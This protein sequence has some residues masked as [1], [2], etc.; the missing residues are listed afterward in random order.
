MAL[1]SGFGDEISKA[2]DDQLKLM[3]ELGLH[4]IELRGI[5]GKGVLDL[6]AEE[7]V[8]A[9]QKLSRA[10]FKVSAIGS[11]IGKVSVLD[12]FEK[13]LAR[14]EKALD[15]ARFFETRYI[16]I[17]SYYIPEGRDPS[18]FETVVISR[19]KE[20]TAR[21][22]SRGII[23]LHENESGIFGESPEQCLAMLKGVDSPF[24][25]AIF[26]TSNF[27]HRDHSAYPEAWEML[28]DHVVYF[29]IKDCS[30]ALG[31]TVP[32]G[33]GDGRM[34]EM[35]RDAGRRG[36]NGFLSLEPHLSNGPYASM[37]RE[38]RF[39]IAVEAIRKVSKEAGLSLE[40]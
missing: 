14:F 1:L 13:E 36:F 12:P 31:Y 27:L 40:E 6:D 5:E 32:A 26:D 33:E 9:K 16:R 15:A 22:Q 8:V 17:F 18:E 19:M 21:A 3:S 10:G 29:H 7:R 11:P 35:L 38:D 2:L 4:H 23:L 34:V 20:K 24:F 30:K 28:R 39:R 25:K 37:A